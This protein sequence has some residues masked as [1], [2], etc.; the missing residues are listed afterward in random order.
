M[1]MTARQEIITFLP[2]QDQCR[3]S[4]VCVRSKVTIIGGALTL[5]GLITI[6]IAGRG[7]SPGLGDLVV[8]L[9]LFV[10]LIGVALAEATGRSEG[11]SAAHRWQP[12]SAER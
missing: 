2:P 5:L 7:D 10:L 8:A 3:A 9:G 11:S 12:G 4:L 6:P 1:G